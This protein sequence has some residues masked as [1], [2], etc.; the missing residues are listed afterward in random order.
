M[1]MSKAPLRKVER[2]AK[3]SENIYQDYTQEKSSSLRISKVMRGLAIAAAVA[4][5][6]AFYVAVFYISPQS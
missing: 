2:I 4:G 5:L 6:V 3:L 1:A